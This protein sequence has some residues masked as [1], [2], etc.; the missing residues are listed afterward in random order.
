MSKKRNQPKVK[1]R[2]LQS[3][4]AGKENKKSPEPTINEKLIQAND[5]SLVDI[6]S[7]EAKEAD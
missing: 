4:P 7:I 3:K 1:R 5:I 6:N 2:K